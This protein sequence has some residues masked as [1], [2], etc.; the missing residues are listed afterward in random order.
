MSV[1]IF[2]VDGT[3]TSSRQRIDFEFETW[4]ADFCLDNEVVLVTGSDRP[5][6]IE[7]LGNFVYSRVSRAYQCSGNQ[8]WQYGK[9]IRESDWR[10]PESVH[11]YLSE[12][13][14]QSHYPVRTGNHFEHRV[15]MCNFSIVGRN[16]KPLERNYYFNWDS[17]KQERADIARCVEQMFPDVSATVGGETSIDLYAKGCDKSQIVG[18]FDDEYMIFFG[19][20]ICENGNDLTIARAIEAKNGVVHSVQNWQE[21]FQILVD[22]YN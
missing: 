2:D 6:T 7:Q 8:V 18:D 10:L 16:A 13:L 17:E 5:K 3:L 22:V 19:D 14:T 1:F 21:T 15:G 4:F 20:M 11:E 9:V 12:R